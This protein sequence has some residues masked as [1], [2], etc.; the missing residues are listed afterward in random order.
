MV[1]VLWELRGPNNISRKP[2]F[3]RLAREIW[4]DQSGFNRRPGK[5]S[6]SWR[7]FKLV[8]KALMSGNVFLI[9]DGISFSRKGICNAKNQVVKSEKYK[10]YFLPPSCRLGDKNR[11]LACGIKSTIMDKSL[12]TNLHL[13]RFFTRA[14]QIH[15]HL[16]IPSPCAPSY[17]AGHVYTLFLQSFYIVLGEGGE[18]TH[19]K[20]DNSA[21]WKLH[22]KNTEN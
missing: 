15:L 17:N 6:L 21:F 11:S 16:F 4:I 2:P 1:C 20:T 18:A 8:G 10:T 5:T 3:I 12:G 14:K 7:Q 22:F 19:F 13:W 9:G